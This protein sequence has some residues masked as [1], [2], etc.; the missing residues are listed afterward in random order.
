MSQPSHSAVE[1]QLAQQLQQAAAQQA[2]ALPPLTWP[3]QRRSMRWWQLALI[4]MATA[5]A[6]AWL[7]LS[8]QPVMHAPVPNVQPS[9]PPMLMAENYHLEALDQ[10]I[11][12]AYV[13][14]ADDT[15]IAQLWQQRQYWSEQQRI[16]QEW[17]Q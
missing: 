17:T 14:G 10:R 2:A 13:Q 16:T 11:Q 1:R 5:A 3:V 4:P 6:V 9:Q 15:T 8:P 12:Q 7:A